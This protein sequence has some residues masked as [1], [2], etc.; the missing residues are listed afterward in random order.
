MLNSIIQTQAF[1]EKR[2]DLG[3]TPPRCTVESELYY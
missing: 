3:F 1:I 2:A